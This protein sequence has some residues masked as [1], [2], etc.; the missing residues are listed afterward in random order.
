V[1]PWLLMGKRDRNA[2]P[3]ASG[4]VAACF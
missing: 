3:R 1:A 4:V 2:N